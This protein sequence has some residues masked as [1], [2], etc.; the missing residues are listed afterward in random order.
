MK[1][2]KRPGIS[3]LNNLEINYPG[4]KIDIRD[5]DGNKIDEYTLTKEDIDN[6]DLKSTDFPCIQGLGEEGQA[7]WCPSEG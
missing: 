2:G 3:H 4:Q 5:D 6:L 1:K 7:R